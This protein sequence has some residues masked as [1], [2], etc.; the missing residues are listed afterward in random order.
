MSSAADP[1]DQVPH[2]A[3]RT[4]AE[5]LQARRGH[6]PTEGDQRWRPTVDP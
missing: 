3:D 6:R 4:E 2:P 1:I 5:A